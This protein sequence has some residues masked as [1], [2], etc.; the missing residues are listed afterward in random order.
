MKFFNTK[1]VM[2]AMGIST[3]A[4]ATPLAPLSSGNTSFLVNDTSRING[5]NGAAAGGNSANAGQLYSLTAF[6]FQVYDVA[7]A[8]HDSGALLGNNTGTFTSNYIGGLGTSV[9]GANFTTTSAVNSLGTITTSGVFF[10]NIAWTKTYRFISADVIEEVFTVQNNSGAA[11]ANFRGFTAYDPDLYSSG[12]NA[13]VASVNSVG[14]IGSYNYALS[15]FAGLNVVLASRTLGVSVGVLANNFVNAD[16]IVALAGGPNGSCGGGAGN[17]TGL[18]V[19]S[20]A[21]DRALAYVFNIN[22]LGAGASQSFT[23]YQLFGNNSFNLGNAL[24]ALPGGS[25]VDPNVVPEPGSLLLMGSACVALGLIARR[26]AKS[27]S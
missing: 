1:A 6:G 5:A 11:V 22:S 23:V 15:T 25:V 12:P 10:G 3:V 8:V 20:A 2:L 27:N 9:P 24:A 7:D 17:S 26:R 21:A 16:C 18:G 14:L 19:S 4:F 13:T